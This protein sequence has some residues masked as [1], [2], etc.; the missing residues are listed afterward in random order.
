MTLTV[1]AA[2]GLGLA[3]QLVRMLDADPS[4]VHAKGGDGGTPLHFS[5]DVAIAKLLLDRGAQIDARDEDHDSTPA[6]WLIGDVPDV[7]RFLVERGASPDIFLA[8]ALG[9]LALAEKLIETDPKCPG[10]RIGKLPE[11][12]PLGS[13]RGGTIYQWTL[14]FNSYPHQIA[15]KKGHQDLF[16]LLYEKSDTAT[17]LLVSCVLGRRAEAEAIAAANPG[18]SRPCPRP[19]LNCLR[20]IAGRPTPISKRSG[21]CSMSASPRRTPSAATDTHHFTTR[22]GPAQE[23]WS[24]C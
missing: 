14:A 22:R 17:R 8:A 7:A 2:S 21:S 12:P 6:Q 13:P 23:I 16:E 15:L 18:T 19:I 9:D 24:I 5:R 20:V 3:D 4:L 11:F 1:H 10:Y